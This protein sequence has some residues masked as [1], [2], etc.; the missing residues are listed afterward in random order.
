MPTSVPMMPDAGALQGTD[1]LYLIQGMN[2]DRDRKVS[3]SEVR[4]FMSERG[5]D[6]RVVNA[7]ASGDW[8][9]DV[10]NSRDLFLYV[11]GAGS[12]K[13]TLEGA[14][15]PGHSVVL[16]N[17]LAPASVEMEATDGN[18]FPAIGRVD[19][20]QTITLHR[21]GPADWACVHAMDSNVISSGFT[22]LGNAITGFANSLGDAIEAETTRAEAAEGT[23]AAGVAAATADLR[24]ID[25]ST[26]SDVDISGDSDQL[27]VLLNGAG[28]SYAITGALPIG[29][30]ATIY[31]DSDYS[32][33]LTYSLTSTTVKLAKGESLEVLVKSLFNPGFPDQMVMDFTVSRPGPVV[34]RQSLALAALS[35][36]GYKACAQVATKPGDYTVSGWV[37]VEVF[38]LAGSITEAVCSLRDNGITSQSRTFPLVPSWKIP[39][40]QQARLFLTIPPTHWKTTAVSGDYCELDVTLTGGGTVDMVKCELVAER[41]SA[42]GPFA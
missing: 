35:S 31:N 21:M 2:L 6:V 39:T 19:R 22:A 10:T 42:L 20:L 26:V 16:W 9:I 14:V 3:L 29:K 27:I 17:I 11:Q 5:A 28:S 32:V 8:S 30:R 12:G 7:P 36:A 40:G 41:V 18:C 38:T 25:L 1:W 33:T 37:E 34:E 13:V 23:I 24:E 4:E 15:P